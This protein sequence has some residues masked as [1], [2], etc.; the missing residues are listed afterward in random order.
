MKWSP[1]SPSVFWILWVLILGFPTALSA[2]PLLQDTWWVTLETNRAV[3]RVSSTLREVSIVCG[4][5]FSANLPSSMAGWDPAFVQQGAYLRNHLE[6]SADGRRLPLELLDWKLVTDAG[7]DLASNSPEYLDETRAVFDFECRWGEGRIPKS[8]RLA[9]TTLED[10]RYAPGIIWEVIYAVAVKSQD[11]QMIG[12]G[13]VR[14]GL[15]MD[16][17]IPTSTVLEKSPDSPAG[18]PLPESNPFGSFLRLGIHHILTGYD[19]LLFLAALALAS[20]HLVDYLRVVVAF[21]LAHSITVTCAAFHWVHVAPWLVEPFIA[22]SIIAVALDNGWI[23]RSAGSKRPLLTA[24]GFGL[25]H[26]L[27][28]ASGLN[29]ALGNGGGMVVAFAIVAFCLGVEIGHLLVGI[30]FWT[31]LHVLTLRNGISFRFR[32]QKWGSVFIAMGGA[33]F[34]V[35]A[36]REYVWN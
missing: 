13:V 15:P 24:F 18:A 23:P 25:V 14:P 20:V 21:T 35:A 34:L 7:A 4:P 36:I 19:H 2:H 1:I 17:I 26:G 33:Y 27:G 5:A 8:L 30:P 22:L 28:F 3:M 9:S 11:K 6:V 32:L 10:Q 29:E 12:S 31:F 16:V